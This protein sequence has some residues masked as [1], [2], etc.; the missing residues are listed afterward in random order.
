[1][2]QDGEAGQP[3]LSDATLALASRARRLTEE[4]VY[5]PIS[6]MRQQRQG[7]ETPEKLPQFL[8]KGGPDSD[9]V[10][11]GEGELRELCPQKRDMP[12]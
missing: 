4:A 12:V 11:V 5:S 1:M 10:W 9:T 6:R 8:E 7:N 3:S 2:W